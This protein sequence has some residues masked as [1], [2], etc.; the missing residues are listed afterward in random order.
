[1][2]LEQKIEQIV[3]IVTPQGA[4][5]SNPQNCV[6]LILEATAQLASDG[7]TRRIATDSEVGDVVATR[8]AEEHTLRDVTSII[9]D[10]LWRIRTIKSATNH[11]EIPVGVSDELWRLAD[12]IQSSLEL[13][14]DRIDPDELTAW[15]N[16]KW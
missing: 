11:A 7:D 2:T 15:L 3:N 6:R 14:L 5:D 9:A 12:A 10:A 13:A 16:T 8:T 1:M 4:F